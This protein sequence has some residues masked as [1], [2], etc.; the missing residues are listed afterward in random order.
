MAEVPE[1]SI[2]IINYN[3][4]ENLKIQ[5][6]KLTGFK[7]V[8]SEILLVDN[9]STDDSISFVKKNYPGIKIVYSKSNVGTAA[10]NLGL[11]ACRGKYVIYIGDMLFAESLLVRLKDVLDKDPSV[12][13][14]VPRIINYFSKKS[15]FTGEI[16]SRSMY[17][18]AK[19]G[20][21]YSKK[22]FEILGTGCGMFRRAD[23]KLVGGIIYDPDYFL[24]GEDID[25]GLRIRLAGK[26][27]VLVPYAVIYHAHL[28][29][30][31]KSFT[32]F[33]LRFLTERNLLTTFVRTF[34]WYN[35]LLWSPYILFMRFVSVIKDI[36]RLDFRSASA[37]CWACLWILLHPFYVS[38]KRSFSQKIRKSDDSFVFTPFSEMG[39]FKALVGM[40]R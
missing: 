17:S 33:Y 20:K 24:Y 2:I 25:L 32:R 4:C 15:E 38:K 21:V 31:A 3:T 6:P 16:I 8:T 14:A 7:K 19:T 35:V 10:M 36:A 23:I 22:P 29:I 40:S 9:A 26:H 13:M 11:K 30:T 18:V 1:F 12:F 5:L 37:R 27:A 34:R 39:F 28:P